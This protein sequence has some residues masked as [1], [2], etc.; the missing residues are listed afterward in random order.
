MLETKN[1]NNERC[2]DKILYDIK[3][4]YSRIENNQEEFEKY[5]QF[6]NNLLNIVEL[7]DKEKNEIYKF[8]SKINLDKKNLSLI[9]EDELKKQIESIFEI[10]NEK[11]TISLI[12]DSILNFNLIIMIQFLILI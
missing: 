11:L 4:N 9:K 3:V 10:N 6:F 8:I 12:Y 5:V 7:D 1:E 2:F